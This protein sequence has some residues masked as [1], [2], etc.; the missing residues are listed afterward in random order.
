MKVVAFSREHF[1]KIKSKSRDATQ[2]CSG[3]AILYCDHLEPL[4][5]VII[6]CIEIRQEKPTGRMRIMVATPLM[7]NGL[8]D[9]LVLHPERGIS[10]WLV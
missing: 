6:R 3:K 9:Y 1:D 2:L 4:T 7:S 10:L 5:R 8:V